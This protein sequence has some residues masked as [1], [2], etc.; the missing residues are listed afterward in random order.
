MTS[1]DLALEMTRRDHD[2]TVITSFPNR[3]SGR[4]MKGYK[5][6][7]KDIEDKDGFRIIRCWHTFSRKST[8]ISRLVENITF[9][10]TTTWRI[11]REKPFDAVYLVNWALV[12]QGMNSWLLAHRKTPIVAAVHD[13]YPDSLVDKGMLKEN[14]AI[15]RW[16]RDFHKRHLQRCAYITTLSPSMVNL[17]VAKRKLPKSRV[18]FIPNWLDEGNFPSNLPKSGTFRQKMGI[19]EDAFVALFA[20]SLTLSAGLQIYLQAAVKLK[21][22]EDIILFLVGDGSMRIQ[23]EQEIAAKGLKNIRVVYPLRPEDT[24]EVQAA[25]DVLLM[26]LSGSMSNSATPSKQVAYMLSGR[27][28][29]ANMESDSYS[30]Q[31][32]IE[33]NAGYVLP[34]NDPGALA[35]QLIKLADDR[36]PLAETG[37]NGRIYALNNYSRTK[38]L[39]KLADLVED[40]AN[41]TSQRH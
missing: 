30:A 26:S 40:A 27:P 5:R 32:L 11:W 35:D 31:I 24:P 23:I 12:A 10:L 3:P 36:K 14:H 29:V 17:L 7:W 1:H 2:V 9:G 33:S 6:K 39:P 4:I 19:P 25:A 38:V 21:S 20:G 16:W 34:P 8:M 37:K 22:R 15:T 28:V 41:H 18:V 13:I